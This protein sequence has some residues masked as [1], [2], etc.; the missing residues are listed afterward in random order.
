MI[1]PDTIISWID[2]KSGKE[3]TG[4]VKEL[5]R[6]YAGRMN[7]SPIDE[8]VIYFTGGEVKVKDWYGWTDLKFIRSSPATVEG[9]WTKLKAGNREL[10]ISQNNFIPVYNTEKVTVGF[11]GE[12]KPDYILKH[13]GK[14]MENQETFVGR[15]RYGENEDSDYA[16]MSIVRI[17]AE[18]NPPVS[19]YELSTKS[20]F[21]NAND[22][23]IY[24]SD[25]LDISEIQKIGPIK[26]SFPA[27]H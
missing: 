18:D 6:H 13:A 15:I 10:I 5:F 3:T 12:Q 1:S 16:D 7:H 27:S 11:H 26:Y 23:Y 8:F 14:I 19:G 4:P 2:I 20:R 25:E 24:A 22:I 17:R 21:V 9:F